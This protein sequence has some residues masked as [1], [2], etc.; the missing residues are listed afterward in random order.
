MKLQLTDANF[1]R[2]AD[3]RVYHLGLRPGEVA[4][5]IVTVGSPSR[6]HAIAKFLDAQQP[7]PFIISSERGFLTIS[8]RHNGVPVS[9][10]SIG[11]GSP[12]MDFFVREVRECL[13][14]DLVIIRLGSCGGLIDVPVGSVVVP[15]AS[16]SVSRNVDYDFTNPGANVVGEEPYRISKPAKADPSLHAELYASLEAAKPPNSKSQI[17]PGTVNA[18]ADSFY[19]SQGR[20]TS[21]PDTNAGLIE[22]LQTSVQDLATLEMETFHLFHLAASWGTGNRTGTV[23]VGGGPDSTTATGSAGSSESSTATAGTSSINIGAGDPQ[24]GSVSASRNEVSTITPLTSI[25]V[26]PTAAIQVTFQASPAESHQHQQQ[27]QPQQEQSSNDTPGH[28]PGAPP[29]NPTST[30]LLPLAL[31]RA[32]PVPT[33]VMPQSLVSTQNSVIRAAAAQMIFASRL[34]QDFITPADVKELEDWTGQAVL[35][36]LTQFPI[37]KNNLH[38]E[39]GSVWALDDNNK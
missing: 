22:R 20:Q 24:S 27:Q 9:I 17:L 12:N 6:A 3:H 28:I 21:F 29:P 32:L 13:S 11:M 14:G 8:G 2:T 16:V 7:N 36:A 15:K 1:P 31:P 38:P 33:E 10:V 26:Q 35:K 30:V 23:H 5:R 19:S 39:E 34:S 4:N 37:P 25:P 18:S